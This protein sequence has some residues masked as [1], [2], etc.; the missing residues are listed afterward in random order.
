MFG[1]DCQLAIEGMVVSAPFAW[2]TAFLSRLAKRAIWECLRLALL[3]MHQDMLGSLLYPIGTYVV[4]FWTCYAVP[5]RICGT[6][7]L[8]GAGGFMRQRLP[9][10]HRTH[11]KLRFY[12]LHILA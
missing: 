1:A 5:D 11:E 4:L 8:K 9:Q 7:Y 12:S 3:V 6:P 2:S 10:L